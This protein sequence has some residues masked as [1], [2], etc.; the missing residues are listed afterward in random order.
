MLSIKPKRYSEA[1]GLWMGGLM[2]PM[3]AFGTWLRQGR[4]F[5]MKAIHFRADVKPVENVEAKFAELATNLAKNDAM[6]RFSTNRTNHERALLPDIHG[7][8]IRFGGDRSQNFDPRDDAQDLLLMTATSLL[9][10]ARGAIATNQKNFAADTYH[11]GAPFV[12]AGQPDMLLRLIPLN[13]V[14]TS[15]TDI[16]QNLRLAV[17]EGDVLF[18]LDT[19]TMSQ[20][21]KWY[22]L[23]EIRLMTEVLVD[24]SRL[25][26]W[27]FRTGRGLEPQGFVQFTR[28]IPYLLCEYAR[29]V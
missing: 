6:A 23:V 15:G 25:A 3:L 13:H 28:Q 20:P 21:D 14:D 8:S 11:G 1:L 29:K 27:P 24:D 5:H 26:L 9:T 16:F 18:R 7:V 22:P 2:A 4:I 17:E 12:V 10:L 19:A